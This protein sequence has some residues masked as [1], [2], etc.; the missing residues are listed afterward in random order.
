MGHL[1]FPD[2]SGHGT[3]PQLIELEGSVHGHGNGVAHSG[4]L[5]DA[6]VFQD[7]ED[8]FQ[9]VR[10]QHAHGGGHLRGFVGQ[11]VLE[12]LGKV[13]PV[14]LIGYLEAVPLFFD[15]FFCQVDFQALESFETA[16]AAEAGY[17]GIAG[18]AG[19]C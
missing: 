2:G 11:D 7:A 10:V 15:H 19:F 1:A 3:E 18:A 17:R 13:S 8:G 4:K 16:P 12:G 9:V 5:D 14:D 6:G